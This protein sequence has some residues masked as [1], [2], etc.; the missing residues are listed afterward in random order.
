MAYL[1]VHQN[2]ASS[3]GKEWK[4]FRLYLDFMVIIN[5]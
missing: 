5:N 2:V 4:Y 1:G 3:E